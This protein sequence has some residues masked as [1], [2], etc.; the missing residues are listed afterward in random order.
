MDT[1]TDILLNC[2]ICLR[3]MLQSV[4]MADGCA[5]HRMCGKQYFAKI[6]HSNK[7][8]LR[9]NLPLQNENL[10][11]NYYTND[12]I[13]YFIESSNQLNNYVIDLTDDE[14]NDIKIFISSS[15]KII[16]LLFDRIHVVSMFYLTDI[17]TAIDEFDEITALSLL[18]N[19]LKL[20]NASTI[21][22]IPNDHSY[23][24]LIL[25]A[26]KKMSRVCLRLLECKNIDINYVD[27]VGDTALI[28]ISD[29][30]FFDVVKKLVCLGAD[31]NHSN[32]IGN[33]AFLVACWGK[34]IMSEKTALF[35]YNYVQNINHQN[36]NG[37]TAISLALK[38]KKISIIDKLLD[39][40]LIDPNYKCINCVNL[41]YWACDN[42]MEYIA[43]KLA[44]MSNDLNEINNDG[45]SLLMRA[46]INNM[47]KL[48]KF[49]IFNPTV[50]LN[51][52]DNFGKTALH[53]ACSNKL[54]NIACRI[55]LMSKNIN[56]ID[57]KGRTLLMHACINNM[58]TLCKVL[59]N[60]PY[61]ILSL[62]LKD[63]Y[64]KTALA[65]ALKNKNNA[66]I[67]QLRNKQQII[68]ESY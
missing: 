28:C 10:L 63:K 50:K 2:L 31:V 29:Y 26:Y 37:V 7:K 6:T 60:K 40:P 21:I 9:T 49:L 41:S 65:Y 5:V 22:N 30:G 25:A 48:C 36:N 58:E 57:V 62:N 33:T 53:Y 68:D 66:I 43:Y 54:E 45:Q 32:S 17:F 64:G 46:C 52:I 51:Q 35:L 56:E 20:P 38:Y 61:S 24:L 23:S 4:I 1:N 55:V 11:D 16:T 3:P 15:P 18:E 34:D 59:L 67:Q 13:K 47:K 27:N 42:D 8:G 44:L 39:N 12:L 14:M 19:L